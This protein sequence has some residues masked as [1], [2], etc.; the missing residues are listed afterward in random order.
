MILSD[1][2]DVRQLPLDILFIFILCFIFKFYQLA[3]K[4]ITFDKNSVGV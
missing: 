4:F 2:L 1:S 3:L